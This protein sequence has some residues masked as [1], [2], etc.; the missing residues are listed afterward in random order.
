MRVFMLLPLLM[1]LSTA[2]VAGAYD[3]LAV[4]A[5]DR[6]API[7]LDVV[8]G[9]RSRTVPIRVFLPGPAAGDSNAPC[10]VVL[11]SHGLGGSREGGRFL[12]DHESRHATGPA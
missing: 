6:A 4:P 1:A 2:G 10:P 7:D 11:F 9:E 3:P 8:N 12:G 5:G